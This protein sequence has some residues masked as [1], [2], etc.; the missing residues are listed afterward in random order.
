[1]KKKISFE[2]KYAIDIP[3]SNLGQEEFVNMGYFETKREAIKFTQKYFG[4]DCKGKI[5][6]I[7]NL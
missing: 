7:N 1:M 4:A 3:N 6:L 2:M 5:N